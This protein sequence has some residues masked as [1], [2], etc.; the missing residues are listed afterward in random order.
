MRSG[1]LSLLA[2][3]ALLFACAAPAFSLTA[4]AGKVDIT[5][6]IK[7]N[8]IY[9]AGYGAKGRRPRGVHDPLHARLLVLSDGKMTL[10]IASFDL[11]GLYAN[12]VEDLRRLSGFDQPGRYLLVAAT[13]DHSGPDTLGLWGPWIGR[14]GVNAAYHAELKA[15]A[16]AELRRLAASLKPARLSAAETQLDPRGLCDDLR[17]PKII[18]PY[19]RVL[20]VR[21][22]DDRPLAT[23]VNWSCHPEVLSRENMLLTADYPGPLCDEIERR[24]GGACVFLSGAV[25]GLMT[26]D[27]KA[28]NFYEAYRVGQTVAQAALKALERAAPAGLAPALTV[29]FEKPLLPIENSR[30]LLFL[31]ALTFGHDLLDSSGNKLAGWKSYWLPIRHALFGL[32]DERRPWI[33]TEVSVIGLGPFQLLGIPGEIFPELVYGGYDGKL[34]AGH[35]LITPGNPGPPDLASAPPGPYLRDKMRGPVRF[36]VGLANDEVGYIVPAYDFKARP[37]LAMHPRMPGHHYEE[38]NSIGPRATQILLES[39]TRLLK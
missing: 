27:I 21:G 16:A 38:T 9:I 37:N 4:A 24:T 6:D 25:G 32:G 30:Y 19:L 15:K 7:K 5:P 13:H 2:I 28:D 34:R 36:V 23:V 22:E 31:R 18:D 10:G 39:A 20:Q 3:V 17:D 29:K 35:D 14:S 11:L 1:P 26:P 33:R 12:D 8:R